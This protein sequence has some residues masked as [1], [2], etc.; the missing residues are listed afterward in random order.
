MVKL[1]PLRLQQALPTL[2]GGAALY[3]PLHQISSEHA[4][5][6]QFVMYIHYACSAKVKN[7]LQSHSHGIITEGHIAIPK[8][9]VG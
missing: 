7:A 8:V 3:H 4:E 2:K 5:P 9:A 1:N 6:K